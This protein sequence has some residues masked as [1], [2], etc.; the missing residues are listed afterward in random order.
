MRQTERIIPFLDI[1]FKDDNLE[2]VIKEIFQLGIEE[3]VLKSIAFNIF[4]NK[5][6]LEEDWV[7][8]P[9]WRF[10]QLLVNTEF[11]PNISGFWYYIEDG[12]ILEQ[13]GIPP[14]EY[15]LWGKNYDKDMNLLSKTER[16]LIK[17]MDTDH[18]QA[19]LDGGWCKSGKYFECFK[20]ELKLRKEE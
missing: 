18:I 19:V 2:K 14:R 1:I 17:D 10:S 12:E 4:I 3:E 15:L 9:D 13:L 20:N 7:S 5:P 16:I 11:L 8:D 6:S